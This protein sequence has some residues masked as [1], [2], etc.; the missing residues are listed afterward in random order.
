MS[1]SNGN[2]C[3]DDNTMTLIGKGRI[4]AE[5]DIA[6]LRLGVETT[7]ENLTTAQAE[8]ARLSQAVL[9]SLRQLGVEDIKTFQYAINRLIV[10]ENNQSIDKGYSVRNILEIRTDNMNQVGLLIDT[11]V[12]NGANVVDL[13]SFEVSDTYEYYLQALNLAVINAS[14]KAKAI[15]ETL[16]IMN[17]P[18]PIRI[19]ENET[20]PVPFQTIGL[21]EG[22]VSTPIEA[23]THQIEA[24]VTV[25]FAF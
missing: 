24:S 11:A 9:Q 20:T 6:V 16:G 19:I 21:R 18:I 15:A 25:V 4:T 3:C 12:Q 5:P 13:I 2:S 23:G 22:F 7:G 10:F 1:Y 14:D 8:N 17:P